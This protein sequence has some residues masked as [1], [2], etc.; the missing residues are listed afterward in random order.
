MPT[1]VPSYRRHKQSGQAIVT[2]RLPDGRRRD[3]LLGRY[4]TPESKAEYRRVLAEAEAGTLAA[5]LPSAAAPDVTL[6]ELLLRFVRFA[7][8]FYPAGTFEGYKDAV[9]PLRRL[10]GHTPAKEF[11]PLALRTYR[12]GLVAAGMARSSVNKRVTQVRRFFKWCVAEQLLPAAVLAGLNAVEGLR[13]GRTAA[14]EPEPVGPPADGAVEAALPLLPAPVA[15]MVNLQLLTGARPGEVVRL[16]ADDFDRS[17]AVW[18]VRL[19][20]HKT[21]HK[22]KGRELLFGPRAQELLAPWLLKAGGGYLFSPAAAEAERNAARSANRT[23]PLYPSHARHN[24]RRRVGGNRKRR[25]GERYTTGAY[26]QAVERACRK[27]GV[28]CWSPNQLRHRA[29]TELRRE[30]GIETAR[31]ILGH[32]TAFTTE[33][34]AEADRAKAADAVHRV[35]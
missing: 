16:R 9:A 26:R 6:N 5:P 24:E 1:P 19:K 17:G 18:V 8:G 11:G 13:A 3:V 22:G 29:A 20:A 4:G 2:V 35:G 25:P 28:P 12:D 21:A 30:F 14:P 34:Y 32:A 15:A 27:A 31:V 7:E 23:T 33:I 10:Y